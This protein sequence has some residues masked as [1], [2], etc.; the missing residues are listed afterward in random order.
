MNAKQIT[1][2]N[3]TDNGYVI[4]K[5]IKGKG[6]E[7]FSQD[8]IVFHSYGSKYTLEEVNSKLEKHS[9]DKLYIESYRADKDSSSIYNLKLPLESF[10]LELHMLYAVTVKKEGEFLGYISLSK[11]KSD[12]DDQIKLCIDLL[13]LQ[14]I[15][16]R[17]EVFDSYYEIDY[18]DS[19][20][21]FKSDSN[22]NYWDGDYIL[23]HGN[24][25]CEIQSDCIYFDGRME[26]YNESEMDF[27]E[28]DEGEFLKD[29]DPEE[30]ICVYNRKYKDWYIGYSLNQKYMSLSYKQVGYDYDKDDCEEEEIL[31]ITYKENKELL[32][33]VKDFLKTE[34]EDLE[35]RS[36]ISN[37]L[38]EENSYRETDIDFKIIDLCYDDVSS[39]KNEIYET[40]EWNYSTIS[41]E[42]LKAYRVAIDSKFKIREDYKIEVENYSQLEDSTYHI[43]NHL[44]ILKRLGKRYNYQLTQSFVS[45][46]IKTIAWAIKQDE[47]EYHF[48]IAEVISDDIIGNQSLKEF[49]VEALEALEK[50]R[51]EKITQK[52]LYEKAARV[53]VSVEDSLKSGN[54][55]FGTMQFISKYGIDLNKI[56]AIRGD[57]L[58]SI[59]N[60][61][62]TT[63]AVQYAIQ[64]VA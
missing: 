46:S 6:L 58:L 47:D 24:N 41:I 8:T 3:I 21:S 18:D 37:E 36:F 52:E 16:T 56:G 15:E 28:F 31:F 9:I 35:M 34:K 1:I 30:S 19:I 14:Q 40:I 27:Y 11:Y 2:K 38:K 7:I 51:F 26:N 25:I 48:N 32:D 10:P 49:I 20:K 43:Y 29:I 62:F 39:L 42:F 5:T 17:D 55:K 63:R 60:S 22:G 13:K 23:K 64:K 59:E 12:R 57:Y 33:K 45:D 53:F 44:A 4:G 61:N 50:R 54:C